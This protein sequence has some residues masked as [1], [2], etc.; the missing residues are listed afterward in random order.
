MFEGVHLGIIGRDW[1]KRNFLFFVSILKIAIMIFVNL[2]I[3]G[4]PNLL[5]QIAYLIYLFTLR[6]FKYDFYN[7]INIGTQIFVIVFY[8][9]RYIVHL[10]MGISDEI[11]TSTDIT[12]I[13]L[14]NVVFV[15]LIIVTY[16][17]VGVK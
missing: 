14:T 2:N 10:Y 6:P 4:I 13:L 16:F 3:S 5:F 8:L 7:Y 11:T 12:R 15:M 17:A 1:K 9:F